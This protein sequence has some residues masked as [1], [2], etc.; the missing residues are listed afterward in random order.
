VRFV[1]AHQA[2][3]RIVGEPAEPRLAFEQGF[4]GCLAVVDVAQIDVEASRVRN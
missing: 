2:V 4:L 1:E 3:L